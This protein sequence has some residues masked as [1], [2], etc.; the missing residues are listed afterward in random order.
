MDNI[1]RIV[2]KS[3]AFRAFVAD[4]TKLVNKAVKI[5]DLF[6]VVAAAMGRTLTAASMMGIDLK[7]ENESISLQISGDGEI[8]NIVTVADCYG[9]VRG[10]VDNPHVELPLKNNKLDVSGAIGTGHLAVAKTIN[11]A[12]P[13]VGRVELQTGEIAE[14]IAYYFMSSQQTP[15]VVALGVLVDVDYTIKA[16]GGYIIQ[17]LPGASD[18]LITKLEANVY[19]LEPVTQMLSQNYDTQRMAREI[20]LGFD[21]EIL[22]KIHPEYKCNCSKEKM[23]KALIS[24]GKDELNSIIDQE[25]SVE[26]C[27]HFCGNK[28]TFAKDD[29]KNI[30]TNEKGE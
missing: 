10:Y 24:L 6:P 28:Y 14:D 4:T 3:G 30:L 12:K 8:K 27:C 23:E 2:E 22:D 5:H 29:L 11:G 20:L 16:A 13:Y 18:E 1:L 9:N 26:L 7:G 21:Y 25:E 17:L 15:S 19:T